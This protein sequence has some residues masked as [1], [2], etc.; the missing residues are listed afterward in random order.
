MISFRYY[1][2]TRKA[3]RKTDGRWPLK[4][5]LTKRGD[6]AL[7][8]V[9]VYLLREEWDAAGQRVTKAHPQRV[10]INNYLDRLRMRVE[11]MMREL[12][13]TGAGAPMTAGQVRDWVAARTTEADDGIRLADY[14]AKVM[15]EKHGR[16][17]ELF[18]NAWKRFAA[19][20]PRV[21]TM[22]LTA[23]D[24]A[25]VLR[26]D[27]KLQ[28]CV[29]LTTRNNYIAKLTQVT[30]RARAE[31]LLA[32]DP[33]RLVHLHYTVPK[34]RALTVEQL[35]TLFAYEPRGVLQERAL[36]A[37]KL[38]FYLRAVNSVDMAR[39]GPECVK[40]G[41]IRYVR[42]KTGKLYDFRVEPEAAALLER[43][44]GRR[45]LFGPYDPVTDPSKYTSCY[46]DKTLHDIARRIGLPE[47]LTMY[48][49]RH[50]LASL[51]IDLGYTMEMAAA[52]LGHSYGPRVTA[53]YVTVQERAV[54]AVVRAVYDYVALTPSMAPAATELADDP[55]QLAE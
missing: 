54:D 26:I 19:I 52:V 37:F 40:N 53:G 14:Y 10:S 7:L 31:G 29:A 49:A 18:A 17:R 34:H 35:R 1:L 32:S 2:D 38:S 20:E 13:L 21:E 27:E 4:M 44:S 45:C 25:T 43:W 51:I 46:I 3:P 16:T 12:I 42:A 50:T 11:D 24:D 6:T 41:R 55:R 15:S 30:K 33:G 36:A 28:S 47:G 9:S 8:P 5:A 39:N 48:W 23:L 22:L